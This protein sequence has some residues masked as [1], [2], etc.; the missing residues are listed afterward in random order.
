MINLLHIVYL[1][2]LIFAPLA[3]GFAQYWSLLTLSLLALLS[4]GLLLIHQLTRGLPLFR[5][6]GL[7]PLLMIAAWVCFS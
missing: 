7:L 5:V 3:F 4:L 2:L 6:P 1:L